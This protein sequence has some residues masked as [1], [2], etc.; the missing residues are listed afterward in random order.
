MAL[1]RSSQDTADYLPIA[2]LFN[3][4]LERYREQSKGTFALKEMYQAGLAGEAKGEAVRLDV[5]DYIGPVKEALMEGKGR[6]LVVTRDVSPGELLMA[7]KAEDIVGQAE[8]GAHVYVPNQ[9]VLCL[10]CVAAST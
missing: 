8:V 4:M 10:C 5:G 2:D 7:I 9:M 6:G 3:V 1:M